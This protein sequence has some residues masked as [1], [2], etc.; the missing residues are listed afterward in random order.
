MKPTLATKFKDAIKPLIPT[1]GSTK[2]SYKSGLKK[3]HTDSVSTTIN[4]QSIN[5]VLGRPAPPVSKEER[6]L[7]RKTRVTLSQLRSGYSSHLYSYLNRINP[8]KYPS[9]DCK[10]CTNT[11]HTTNHLFDCPAN[12]TSL[13]PDALW[14]D[15]V[16]A[17]DLLGLDR[18]GIG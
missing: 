15:P 12:P 17:A 8:S 7:P 3:I 18:H 5:K 14:H 13:S 6:T 1:G 10:D 9:P 2:A 16:S 11:P 4:N